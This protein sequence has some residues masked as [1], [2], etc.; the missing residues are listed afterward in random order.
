[1]IH[2]NE[3][4][5]FI[6]A[7]LTTSAFLPQIIKSFKSKKTGHLSLGL[8]AMQS[9]GNFLWFVYGLIL[10]SLALILANAIT[11]ILVFALLLFKLAIEKSSAPHPH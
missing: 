9:M 8:L 10:K 3:T 11:F 4:I 2:I 1:M 5:G 6:A 7:I